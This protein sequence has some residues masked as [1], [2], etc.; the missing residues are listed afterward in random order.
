MNDLWNA[1]LYNRQHQFVSELGQSA[2]QLLNPTKDEHI[3]DLGCGTGDLTAK[4]AQHAHVIG[5]DQSKNMI[6]LAKENYPTLSFMVADACH[7]PFENKYLFKCRIALDQNT[8]K[9]RPVYL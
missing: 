4:I 1:Q 5:I 3:L 7:L 2:L 6:E 9:G 8:G